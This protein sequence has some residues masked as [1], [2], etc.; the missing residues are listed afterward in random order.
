M[1]HLLKLAALGLTLWM[2]SCSAPAATLSCSSATTLDSLATCIRSQMPDSESN[3]FVAPTAAEQAGWR[4]VVKQ[5]LQGSCNFPLPASIA[6]A[7]RMRTFTDTNSS[8]SYC[9]LMEVVDANNNGVVDRGWGTFLVNSNAVLEM[10]HQA[11]HPIADS[12]TENQAIG[13]FGGTDSRSYLMAGSHR[14]AN[15]GASSCQK[16]Y[17]PADA[18]HNIANMFQATNA[19]LIVFYG[20]RAWQAISGTAWRLTPASRR[21]HS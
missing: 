14:L 3:G 5:M 9:L 21:M 18:A 10:S 20:T 16:S 11:P 7:A 13:V 19:E 4:A 8:K 12:T 17:G 2:S 6:A 1:R 15:S